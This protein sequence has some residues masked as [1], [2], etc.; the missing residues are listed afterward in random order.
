M[1]CGSFMAKGH[2]RRS[3]M[4][5]VV[6]EGLDVM[7]NFLF[8]TDIMECAC[9]KPFRRTSDRCVHYLHYWILTISEILG[10]DVDIVCDYVETFDGTGVFI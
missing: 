6:L 7:L 4:F 10:T 2:S 8:M 3:M 1:S 5:H 9:A